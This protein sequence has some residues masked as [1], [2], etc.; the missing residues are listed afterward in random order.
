MTRTFRR[1][2]L[3]GYVLATFLAFPHPV[4]GGVLDLGV[5]CA[6]LS[7]AL[8]LIGLDGLAPGRAARVG[9]VAGLAAHSAI[10][11]WIYVV[12]VVYGHAPAAV[13]VVAPVLLAAYVAA[14][15]SGF[16]AGCAWLAARGAISS[17]VWR[18]RSACSGRAS[19]SAGW[20]RTAP[21]SAGG[22]R[23]PVLHW[24]Q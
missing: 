3:V 10:L 4:A 21:W 16:G 11:H 12:T 14:F 17:L 7:P 23:L 13:G 20:V 6:W 2:S 1:L 19:Q 9:F 22:C 18:L 8:L 5:V 24:I 15:S